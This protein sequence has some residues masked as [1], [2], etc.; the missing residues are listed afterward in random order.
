MRLRR[1]GAMGISVAVLSVI[2]LN[3]T[4]AAGRPPESARRPGTTAGIGPPLSP[5]V[6]PP[7][8]PPV[9]PDVD[10]PVG[11]PLSPP[12]GPPLS[13]PVGPPLSPPVGP[14]TSRIAGTIVI[15]PAAT[16]PDSVV[17]ATAS[18]KKP[19]PADTLPIR[20]SL[21]VTNPEVGDQG[22]F[23]DIVATAGN[24]SDCV[25]EPTDV[26]CSWDARSGSTASLSVNI[27]VEAG[28]IPAT[29]GWQVAALR[30]VI[31]GTGEGTTIT[32]VT[33][34]TASLEIVDEATASGSPID[35][36]PDDGAH[37]AERN[38]RD[39]SRRQPPQA[40]R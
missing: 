35:V 2:V 20:M 27:L 28:A 8:S 39:A 24:I 4:V 7:L 26:V 11:P 33:L 37:P 38:R 6:G 3:I 13:P 5:P 9:G 1:A 31:T 18:F 19:G 21:A 22:G 32:W 16:R 40:W 14:P 23:G 34:A 29:P 25:V 17:V 10:R 36:G 30:G 12:V 15:E